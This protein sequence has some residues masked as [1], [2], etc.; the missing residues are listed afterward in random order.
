M[1]L[2]ELSRT[3]PGVG[4]QVRALG[5]GAAAVEYEGVA[6]RLWNVLVVARE[7]APTR[8]RT[9]CDVHPDGP[10]DPL[11]P[12]GWTRCLLCNRNRRISDPSVPAVE[13]APEGARPGAGYAAP[14]PPYTRE[15]LTEAMRLV[16]ELAFELDYGSSDEKFALLAERVHRAFVIARELS[17]PRGDSGCSRHPG[18]PVDPTA[19]ETGGPSCLFCRG[20]ELRRS[21]QGPPVPRGRR[22]RPRRRIGY[23][24]APP[25]RHGGT[26]A[27]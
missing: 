11:A 1:L 3:V 9:G 18:A 13:A 19:D 24:P 20:E 12:P 4:D 23:R 8:S 16:N 27:G 10:V 14:S 15:A 5:D 7:L 26:D 6:D 25:H 22:P 2:K 17:R 21:R